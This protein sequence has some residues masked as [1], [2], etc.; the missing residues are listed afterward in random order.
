MIES[1]SPSPTPPPPTQRMEPSLPTPLEESAATAAGGKLY[2]IGGF[3]AAGN[4]LQTVWVFD[5]NAWSA[6]PRMPIGLDHTSAATLDDHVYVAGG[7][8][9]GH[10]SARLYRLDGGL[11][12]ELA[13]M[14]HARGGHALLAAAA[15]LYAIGGNAASTNVASAEVYDPASNAW[16]DL[17]SLPAPRNHVSGFVFGANVC[18]AGGR[19]PATA[20]VDCFNF[21]SSSWVRF[22]DLPRATS[23]AGATTLD[24]ESAVIL[25]GENAQETTISDQFARLPS[26]DG[27]MSSDTMLVPR[28]GFELATFEG[29]AWACGGGSLPGLHPVSTCTSVV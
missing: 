26:P 27:W 2:V 16:S 12:T 24:G 13:S 21:E 11:W 6:G 19:P 23:G 22:P 28:H 1:P 20:R 25:G 29:R 18:V 9:F 17:P 15:K 4:S 8:S 5:G 3:D 7:H 14:H 10:D